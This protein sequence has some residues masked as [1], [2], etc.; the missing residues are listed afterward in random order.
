MRFKKLKIAVAIAIVIFVL[1]VANIIFMG[2]FN[3]TNYQTPLNSNTNNVQPV[4][5]KPVVKNVTNNQAGTQT[6]PVIVAP[7]TTR[8]RVVQTPRTRAS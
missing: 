7:T 8:T 5:S 6:T 4:V 3:S 2:S 1:V